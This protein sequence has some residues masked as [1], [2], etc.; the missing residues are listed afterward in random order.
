MPTDSYE[1]KSQRLLQQLTSF[2]NKNTI[3]LKKTTSNL[4]RSAKRKKQTLDVRAFNQVI[5]IDA[6]SLTMTV[7]GM[8][9]FEAVVAASLQ[10]NLIPLVVPELKTITVGGAISGM[11]IESSSFRYGLMHESVVSMDV[12]TGAGKIVTCTPN[13]PHS[14]LFYGLPNSY[15]TLGYVLKVTIKVRPVKPYVHLRHI[16]FHDSKEYFRQLQRICQTGTYDGEPVS[17]IDG[18]AFRPNKMYITIGIETNSA[19]KTSNYTYKKIYYQSIREKSDDYLT[20]HDYLWR[21]D[22]D[23][24]WCS[25]NM[26]AD[27]PVI[28]RIYGPKRLGSRTYARIMRLEARLG[29]YQKITKLI[30]HHQPQEDVIQDIE[31]PILKAPAFIEQFDTSVGI[32][33]VWI[34]PTKSPAKKWPYPLYPIKDNQL[35]VNFGFWDHVPAWQPAHKGHYNKIVEA[36]VSELGGIKSLYSNSFYERKDFERIYNYGAYIPL[37]KKYDPNNKLRDLYEKCAT[38]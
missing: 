33:P 13:G 4:F 10:Y 29:V 28:R 32:R 19:P 36:L 22:T 16:R 17:F 21:W 27:R 9:T 8:T 15:G 2:D 18:T 14:D 7:E 20:I 35:Y 5:S 31:V 11:A 25:K 37:K 24:F 30:G 38:R 12:L 1:V 26:F 6:T 3:G 23:W 34:C